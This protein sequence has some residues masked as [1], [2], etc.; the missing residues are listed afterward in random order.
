MNESK[1][2]SGA[3]VPCIDLLA[4]VDEWERDVGKLCRASEDA[5]HVLER[6]AMRG[7]AERV[8][9]MADKV[10]ILIR[11]NKLN[12]SSKHFVYTE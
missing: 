1:T 2:P 4:L 7:A 3:A 5:E 9:R 6:A 8:Q 12:E 10:R 11:A